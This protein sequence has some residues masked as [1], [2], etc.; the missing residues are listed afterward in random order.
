LS[1][2]QGS[3][4]VFKGS[5]KHVNTDWSETWYMVVMTKGRRGQPIDLSELFSCIIATK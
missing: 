4:H 2:G 3:G 1:S 5:L